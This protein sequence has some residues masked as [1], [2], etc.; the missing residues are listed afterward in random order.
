MNRLIPI[1]VVVLALGAA[2]ARGE[3]GASPAADATPALEVTGAQ[4]DAALI[5]AADLPAGA[6]K[7]EP[8][9]VPSTVQV[10]GK[11]GPANVKGAEEEAIVA[12]RKEGG[13]AYVTT[14]IYLVDS[15]EVAQQVLLAHHQAESQ[16]TWTQERRDGGGARFKRVG[17]VKG[18]PA[19]GDETYSSRLAVTVIDPSKKETE[20]KI[21]YVAFRVNRLLAFVITQDTDSIPV[22][23]RQH[24]K[25]AKLAA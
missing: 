22:A 24:D 4:I 8:D 10:G 7:K 2:C 1:T 5:T 19:L 6:W 17:P 9:P 20:R 16:S 21:H 12:F 15:A 25:V 18:M 13:S 14:S 3:D 11:V 23:K